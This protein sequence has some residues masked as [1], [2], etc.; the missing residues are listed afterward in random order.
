MSYW[1]L[2]IAL[3]VMGIIFLFASRGGCCLGLTLLL[4]SIVLIIIG[5]IKFWLAASVWIVSAI[6]AIMITIW[7]YK[8]VKGKIP[9]FRRRKK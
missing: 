2:T 4:A 8:S 6:I 9:N 1:I 7:I 3:A 5:T